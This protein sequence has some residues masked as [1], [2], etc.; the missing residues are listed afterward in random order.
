MRVKLLR[1]AAACL[2][3]GVAL[4][5]TT[6]STTACGGRCEVP[7][8]TIDI[9][10]PEPFEHGKCSSFLGGFMMLEGAVH[11]DGASLVLLRDGDSSA[12]PSLGVDIPEGTLVR[13]TLA[14]S[15]AAEWNAARVVWIQNL[16]SLNGTTNPTESG[17]R[18][19][20]FAIG[21]YP[22]MYLGGLPVDLAFEQVC[23]VRDERSR[24]IGVEAL[25]L[26]SGADVVYVPPGEA[27][28]FTIHRGPEA[29]VYE[30]ENVNITFA[31][32]DTSDIPEGPLTMNFRVARADR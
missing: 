28:T 22:P 7:T 19:W 15:G 6:P 21:G 30:V 10:F 1:T 26:A 11:H 8:D 5:L 2:C 31:S 17:E 24:T 18:T 4:A 20:L 9:V 16:P 25:V 14:C 27:R 29:G 3:A 23:A 13:V 12:F 32:F